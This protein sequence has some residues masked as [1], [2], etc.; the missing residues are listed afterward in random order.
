MDRLKR[1]LALKEAGVFLALVALIVVFALISEHFLSLGTFGSI[2]TVSTEIGIIALGATILMMAGEF[3]LSVGSNFAFCGMVFALLTSTYQ[4]SSI[5]A[6]IA[7]LFLGA[8][9]GLMNGLITVKTRIPSFI[10]TLGTMLVFRGVVL[11]V[12][13]GFP[14]SALEPNTVMNWFGS[15][16]THG[17]KSSLFVWAALALVF[18]Y[19]I[20]AHPFGNLIMATGGNPEASYAMGI[21]VKRVKL[22]SFV[23]TGTLAALAGVIQYSHLLTLSPTAGEQYEL[24]AIAIAVIGGTLLSGG[25]GTIVGTVLGTLIMGVLASGLV[26]AGVSTYWFRALVGVILVLAVIGNTYWQRKEARSA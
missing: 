22:I 23:I 14:I 8:S 9:I 17:F 3:D 18:I 1:L 19:L 16:L 25:V 10:A 2:L 21:K 13:D 7:A 11:L 4:F 15:D 12:T 26:Q 5:G 20:N 6:F 24:R